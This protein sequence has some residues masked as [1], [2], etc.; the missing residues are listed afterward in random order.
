MVYGRPNSISSVESSALPKI[1]SARANT[2]CT[3]RRLRNPEA[4]PVMRCRYAAVPLTTR[5][6]RLSKTLHRRDEG[7]AFVA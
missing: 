3:R 5:D 2:A 1:E 4:P 6:N 7:E